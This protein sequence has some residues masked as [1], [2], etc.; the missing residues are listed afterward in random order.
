MQ[1]GILVPFMNNFGEKGFYNS[2]EVGLGKALVKNGND[3]VIYKLIKVG[4]EKPKDYEIGNLK[5]LYLEAKSIGANGIV[6]TQWL[7]PKMNALICFSDMQLVIPKIYGWCKKNNIKFIPYIGVTESHST[8]CVIRFVMNFLFTRNINVYRKCTCIVKNSIVIDS[9]MKRKVKDVKLA[10]VGIDTDLLHT[11]YDG[12]AKQELKEKYGYK[13]DEHVLLFI[14]R[15]EQE[16]EPIK[17][18]SI[19]SELKREDEKLK[20]LIVG[21]GSLQEKME[22]EIAI[23]SL[24]ND[25]QHIQ[26]IPNEHIWELYRLCD[27]FVNLNHQEIF[28][29]VL[30]EAMYYETVVVAWHAPGPDFIINDKE[31]GY[32]VSNMEELKISLRHTDINIREKAH[33][34]V[35]S[36]FTWDSTALVVQGIIDN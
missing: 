13:T 3:V 23:H 10:P 29:M 14:G 2:Q 30:L 24:Q 25:V 27:W 36:S 28:G 19:F 7:N 6:D 34:R 35:M 17:L 15:L 20:L 18:I 5:V 22:K 12:I 1:I 8:N 21:K 11:D 9:L 4:T 26:Q 32:L 33:E 31:S 16:K